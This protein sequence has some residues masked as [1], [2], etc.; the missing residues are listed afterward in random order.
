[1]DPPENIFCLADAGLCSIDVVGL[2]G[3]TVTPNAQRFLESGLSAIDVDDRSGNSVI[4]PMLARRSGRFPLLRLPQEIR[5]HVLGFLLPDVKWIDSGNEWDCLQDA[6]SGITDCIWT[7]HRNDGAKC[8]MAIMRSSSQIYYELIGYLYDRMTVIAHIRE[9]GV[10]FL[11]NHWGCCSLPEDDFAD[12]PLH[13]F[14]CV[15]IQVHASYDQRKHLVHVR[16][17][18]LDFCLSLSQRRSLKHVRVDFWDARHCLRGGM[19]GFYEATGVQGGVEVA[20]KDVQDIMDIEEDPE[21]PAERLIWRAENSTGTRLAATDMELILQPLKLMR[22]VKNMQIYLNPYLQEHALLREMVAECKALI[23]STKEHTLEDLK[24]IHDTS[25]A[26]EH[27]WD[28]V[29][30][31]EERLETLL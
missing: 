12:V 8:E 23:E 18:L 24:L 29:S 7:T 25:E 19:S 11:S 17:N 28:T 3:D 13:K 2:T 27:F 10:D 5:L 1:M 6:G 9:H 21:G 14:K 16:R 22:N 4:S 30:L 26:L 31:K 15:W 20:T